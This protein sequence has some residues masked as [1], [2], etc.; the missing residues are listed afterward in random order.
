MT[1]LSRGVSWRWNYR[2][3]NCS[4]GI[5]SYAMIS[6]AFRFVLQK[7][8]SWRHENL[9]KNVN[10]PRKSFSYLHHSTSIDQ[11]INLWRDVVLCRYICAHH[12]SIQILCF[13]IKSFQLFFDPFLE[14]EKNYF[15]IES[16]LWFWI[17]FK[18]Q[19]H[20]NNQ[21]KCINLLVL[22]EEAPK[23]FSEI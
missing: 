2:G 3:K 5:F 4:A 1:V 17:S 6:A 14:I 20:Q 18:S 12:I 21:A 23:G 22:F 8:D 10:I 13:Q 16:F 9:Q 19:W 7:D 11:A 15:L